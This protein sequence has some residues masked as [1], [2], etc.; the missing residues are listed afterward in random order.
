MVGPA[1]G[2]PN[3]TQRADQ[4]PAQVQTLLSHVW[5]PTQPVGQL[6]GR[7]TRHG[8]DSRG[9][10]AAAGASFEGS[11][12]RNSKH[13]QSGGVQTENFHEETPSHG[14]PGTVP[15][16]QPCH[17]CQPEPWPQISSPLRRPLPS[18]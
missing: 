12:P 7:G 4:R 11:I 10:Q 16:W 5:P 18:H 13:A 9:R 17:A 14:I 3:C 8:G 6:L 15:G 1:S 2:H